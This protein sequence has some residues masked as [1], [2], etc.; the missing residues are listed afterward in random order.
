MNSR[1]KLLEERNEAERELLAGLQDRP[2]YDAKQDSQ[3]KEDYYGGIS[4]EGDNLFNHLNVL[5]ND[6][7]EKKL[8]YAPHRYIYPWVDLHENGKLRSLYS[9]IKMEPLEAIDQD[10]QM[11]ISDNF[12]TFSIGKPL[13]CEH[14]VPQSWFRHEEPMKG[15]LHHLFS[16]EPSCNSRRGNSPYYDFTDYVPEVSGIKDGCGKAVEG[17]FE[18]EYGKGIV[19]RATLYFLIKYKNA[20]DMGNIDMPILLQWHKAFP[21]SIYEKHRNAAIQ[22]LQGNRNPL[23]DFPDISILLF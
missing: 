5:L 16:C 8:E 1:T 17:K 22:D 4:F 18:P 2:Y 14:V 10:Y 9:G 20:I 19:A 7:H 11:L 3:R 23:I 15:D 21:V 12:I 6:T 13:N